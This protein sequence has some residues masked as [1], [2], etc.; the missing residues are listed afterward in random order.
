[1]LGVVRRGFAPIY[2]LHRLGMMS[3]RTY[4][5]FF[6][7]H[8]VSGIVITVGLFVIFFAGAFTLF[9][10]EI[11]AWEHSRERHVSAPHIP[12]GKRLDL[13]RLVHVLDKKGY[14]LYGRDIYI[15]LQVPGP[16]QPLYLA[17]SEDSLATDEAKAYKNLQLNRETYEVTELSENSSATLGSLLY[18]LHF[19]YQLGDLGYYLSGLVSLFFLFAMVSGIIVHWKKIISNFYLFRP[20]EKLK[21]VWTDAHTALGVIGIPFQFMYALTGAWFGLGILVAAS[22][23]LLYDG[24]RT[25]YYDELH[26]HHHDEALGPRI[27]LSDY[28]LNTLLDSASSKWQG[29]DLT[30]IALQKTASA[31]MK[32]NIYGEVDAKH[33]FFNF[34]ELE[35]DVASGR[36]SHMHDP[37]HKRYDEVVSAFIHRIHFGYFGLEGWRHTAVKVLYFLLAVAT[38]FVIISGV[39]IWL[40]ARNK[41]NIPEKKRKFNKTVGHI[42][43]AVCLSMLPVTAFTFLVTKLLPQS[44]DEHRG[45]II[46]SVFFGGWLL[47]SIFFWLKR[48]NSFTNNYTLLSAGILGGCIPIANGVVSGNWFWRT[49]N[50]NQHQLFITDMLWLMLA[51]LSLIT[52]YVIRR[53]PESLGLSS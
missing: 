41:K 23:A 3:K 14:D 20:Y 16:L 7:L 36:I 37:Y 9:F 12:A 43:L 40:E 17:G 18:D 10:Q 44:L 22:S 21:T 30:Y 46:S 39:L 42:Y 34:G 51:V 5:I 50:G 24:D 29:F 53:R 48:N 38:C 45:T 32:I 28:P 49:L 15:D 27:K 19:F 47:V 13:D 25:K 8:T 52:V 4:N 2:A 33:S 6:H 11:E 35:F 1:M 26:G 31:A